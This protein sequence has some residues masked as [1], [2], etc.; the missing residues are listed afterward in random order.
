MFMKKKLQLIIDVDGV[1][2]DGSF[3]YDNK[4]KIFK[5]FGPHDSDGIKIIKKFIDVFLI[6][7]DKRG[8]DISKKRAKDIGLKIF[9]VP[10]ENRYN[11]FE[12]IGFKQCIFIGDGHY[13]AEILKKVYYGIAPQ[14]AVKKCKKNSNYVT[15]VNGGNGAVYE[16][17]LH[18]MKKL[19]FKLNENNI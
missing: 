12:N 4:G 10:E 8:Y 6:S 17:C 14:N 18:I 1:L 2:T 13:D 9:Y 5:K 15:K 11:F 19:K 3:I 16:A 7:A